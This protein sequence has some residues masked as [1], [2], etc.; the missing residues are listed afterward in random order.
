ME[1]NTK[2]N[3][4]ITKCMV[5]GKFLDCPAHYIIEIETFYSSFSVYT[6][7]DGTVIEGQFLDDEYAGYSS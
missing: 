5:Q 1:Q 7:F 2:G 6:M 3:G 4:S